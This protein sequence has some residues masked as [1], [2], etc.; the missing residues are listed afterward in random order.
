[1]A[2]PK[3]VG[4]LCF[5]ITKFFSRPRQA[6]GKEQ[7]EQEGLEQLL[8]THLTAPV[9][10]PSS[11]FPSY[12]CI[13]VRK[14]QPPQSGVCPPLMTHTITVLHQYEYCI[15]CFSLPYCHERSHLPSSWNNMTYY[16]KFIT[17]NYDFSVSPGKCILYLPSH[18]DKSLRMT[19]NRENLDLVYLSLCTTMW[20]KN[21]IKEK[22]VKKPGHHQ[23]TGS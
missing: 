14:M 1:M 6:L 4:I 16:H 19:E 8:P 3:P 9:S 2:V 12:R 21:K 13:I 20:P 22:R 23:N 11:P 15:S 18:Q 10:L 5:S 7:R 17:N